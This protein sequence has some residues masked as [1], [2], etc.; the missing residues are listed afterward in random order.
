MEM[1]RRTWDEAPI[2]RRGRADLEKLRVRDAMNL[3][4]PHAA[5]RRVRRAQRRHHDPPKAGVTPAD[6]PP[7]YVLC[8][9]AEHNVSCSTKVMD[10]SM[11]EEAA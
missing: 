6:D 9:K 4:D 5:G 8:A 11:R 10:T 7:A 3:G 1:G 2:I